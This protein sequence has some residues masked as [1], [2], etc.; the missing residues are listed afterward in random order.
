MAFFWTTKDVGGLFSNQQKQKVVPHSSS[1]VGQVGSWYHWHRFYTLVIFTTFVHPPKRPYL[2]EERA[3]RII[4]F[5]FIISSERT[6]S[7]SNISGG[8]GDVDTGMWDVT[9]QESV[10]NLWWFFIL[11]YFSQYHTCKLW[12]G[13]MSAVLMLLENRTVLFLTVLIIYRS[14]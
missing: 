11:F 8:N 2:K 4:F 12:L 3:V 14:N 7:W 10:I 5:P 9:L 1:A 13:R 6:H